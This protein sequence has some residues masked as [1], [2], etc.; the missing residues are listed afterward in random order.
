MAN[1]VL[2]ILP[3]T[4]QLGDKDYLC[5][6]LAEL[7]I[8]S[9]E[10]AGIECAARPRAA[11]HKGPD[12]NIK[13]AADALQANVIMTGTLAPGADGNPALQ[14]KLTTMPEATTLWEQSY[15]YSAEGIL[16][17]TAQ[18]FIDLLIGLCQTH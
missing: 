15:G 11:V 13:T 18:V 7:L 12:V 6:G 2:A 10:R 4:D 14:L 5:E 9:A 8:D 1:K 17:L 3:I 16:R